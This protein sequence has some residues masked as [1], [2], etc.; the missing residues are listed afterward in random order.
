MKPVYVA[1]RQLILTSPRSQERQITDIRSVP[2]SLTPSRF[3]DFSFTWRSSSV[4]CVA[5]PGSRTTVWTGTSARECW[6]G[7][8]PGS[9]TTVC[10]L[11]YQ[12]TAREQWAGVCPQI[13][14]AACQIQDTPTWKGLMIHSEENLRIYFQK[15][16]RFQKMTP[17]I[18]VLETKYDYFCL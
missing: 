18:P 6:A 7:V 12:E 15:E 17:K 16:K 4:A 9:R 1:S 13:G 2:Q 8:K 14:Q 5:K 3:H 11:E 10:K